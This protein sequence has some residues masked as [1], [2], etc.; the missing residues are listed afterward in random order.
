VSG[1]APGYSALDSDHPGCRVRAAYRMRV[2]IAMLVAS[3]F[4]PTLVA[5]I[6]GAASLDSHS[7]G[8]PDLLVGPPDHPIVIHA[9]SG[10]EPARAGSPAPSPRS[11]TAQPRP[12]KRVPTRVAP[13]PTRA[14]SSSAT[15]GGTTGCPAGPGQC[16]GGETPYVSPD[17]TGPPT[18]GPHS[19][20]SPDPSP[21]TSTSPSPS[22]SPQGSASPSDGTDSGAVASPAL[23]PSSENANS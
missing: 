20:T 3:T 15:S 21:S 11:A 23:S 9:P 19:S 5:I 4:V 14:S 16:G 8:L 2:L 7:P 13:K 17:P 18:T 12:A 6:A 10:T 1:L 22:T